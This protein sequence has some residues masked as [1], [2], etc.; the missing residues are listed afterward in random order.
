MDTIGRSA[1]MSSLDSNTRHIA[2]VAYGET[3]VSNHSDGADIKS[4]YTKHQKVKDGIHFG[5]PSHN[6][7]NIKE[8]SQSEITIYWKVVNKKQVKKYSQKFVAVTHTY[9]FPRQLM[10]AQ[11]FGNIMTTT[12]K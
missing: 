10:A 6:I 2:A 1:K 5:D 3:D 11:Y 9:G 8:S 12:L 7:Y 4:N